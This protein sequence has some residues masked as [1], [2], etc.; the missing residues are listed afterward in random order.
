MMREF[1]LW[2][3]LALLLVLGTAPA[4]PGIANRVKSALTGRRG[5]PV[6]QL[7]WDLARLWRKGVVYS[8]TT[9]LLFRLAPSVL[10]ATGLLAASLLP[11]DGR[12]ALLSFPG[13][14]VAFAGLLALGR[15]L[16]I[17]SSLDTG[18]SFEGMGAS[19]EATI[20]TFAEPALFL[21]FTVVV[22]ATGQLQLSGMFG[23]P[24]LAAWAPA[25]PSLVLAAA[26]LFIVTLAEN[27]R[28][29]VDDPLTHLELTMVHEVMVLDHSG[30][31]FALILYAGA[32]K[33]ALFASLIVATLLPRAG[34][35]ALLGLGELLLGMLA[36]ALVV[37]VVEAVMA[38]LRLN[39]VPQLLIAASAL[40]GFGL[41][42]LLS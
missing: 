15:F 37:G 39:R 4:L 40:A 30:P 9:T 33:L 27:C 18:S 38:R 25:A 29:P 42:L 14:L 34:H 41:I 17:L 21:C 12:S 5:A 6:L 19:R 26:S 23:R 3:L 22:L 31:D 8:S 1:P 2:P 20:A 28:V 13:D 7:Y 32:L 36:V 16:L 35:P 11:L 10:L 24:L